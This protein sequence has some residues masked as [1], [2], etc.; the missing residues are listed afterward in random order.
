MSDWEPR[1]LKLQQGNDNDIWVGIISLEYFQ[2][3]EQVLKTFKDIVFF[4][5]IKL[6]L[7]TANIPS[8]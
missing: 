8:H 6:A 7:T 2:V 1:Q 5:C 4:S 3:E